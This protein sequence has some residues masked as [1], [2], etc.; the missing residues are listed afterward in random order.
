[1]KRN[2]KRITTDA[3]CVGYYE[4]ETR[5]H[6]RA[7]DRYYTLKHRARGKQVEE[8]VG[9]ASD[10]YSYDY[11]CDLMRTLSQNKKDGAG[12]V[13]LAELREERER[14][15][16][17]EAHAREAE[18]VRRKQQAVT[19]DEAADRFLA[20]SKASKA[21]HRDDRRNLD[22]HAREHVTAW[23]RR[24]GSMPMGEISSE[25][26]LDLK[27][28]LE[29]KKPRRGPRKALSPATVVHVLGT[30]REVFNYA[31]HTPLE[32]H[33]PEV[34]LFAGANP[35]AF[36]KF[37]I[38][39]EITRRDNTTKRVIHDDEIGAY[40]A[41]SLKYS[42]D[43]YDADMIARF[44]GM[45]RGEIVTLKKQSV[46]LSGTIDVLDPKDIDSRTVEFDPEDLREVLTRRLAMP[47]DWLFP[48]RRKTSATPHRSPDSI[49]R[50]FDRCAEAVGLNK[51]VTDPRYRATFKTWRTTYAVSMLAAGVSLEYLRDQLGHHDISLTSERYLPLVAAYRRE[52][53]LRASRAAKV[54]D[55]RQ[56]TP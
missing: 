6:G 42:K 56:G 48:A 25:T 15:R 35:A 32:A 2:N 10:G 29:R 47:G 27:R 33:R 30:V 16:E 46:R 8:G 40:L 13:T 34:K 41:A 50:G 24:F 23:G 38:G 44:T 52:A 55:F 4:H 43:Q 18:D 31:M 19:F 51:G 5:K 53:L 3:K 49:T 39:R 9:W 21:S 22:L 7:P 11:A 45:R 14:V 26:I 36:S 37:G 17:F 12:P 54:L 20:W 1:M 28:A